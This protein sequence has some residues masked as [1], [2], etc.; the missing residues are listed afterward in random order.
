MNI[1][2]KGTRF[3][4]KCLLVSALLA[5]S[6]SGVAQLR[7]VTLDPKLGGIKITDLA[8][9][10]LN[11]NFIQPGQLLKI[12]VPVAN[13]IH[14]NAVPKGSCKI[15]IGLGSKLLLDPQLD[16]TTVNSSNYFTWT[17]VTVGGQSL[18]TG[19]LTT[20]LPANFNEVEVAFK[21]L[22]NQV[23][24]STITANFLVTNH[25]TATILSDNDGSNNATFLKYA[26]TNATAP[27]P[28]TTVDALSK[29]DCSIKIDFSTDR[30]INISH[31]Q[32][33]AS[34]NAVDYVKVYQTNAAALATYTAT[35]ALPKDLQTPVL[36]VRAKTTYN[37]GNVM[38]SDAK[39][40]SGLCEGKWAVDMYPNPTRGNEDVVIR[41]VSG[42]FNGRYTI[43]LVDLTGRT[44]QTHQV[45]LNNVLNFKYRIGNL[46]A[47]K[48][49]LRIVNADA[50]ETA[51]LQFEKL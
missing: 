40:V 17:A 8:G 13:T 3:S 32:L 41:A 50:S 2:L 48:Y 39:T 44:I 37:N 5:A 34:K 45:Q 28:T 38:Y 36:Y 6:L 12:V 20:A 24:H 47:S 19:E 11:E 49:M 22:G 23:G 29:S 42:M 30:E 51:L 25:N 9:N 18:L 43:N 26:I 10:V 27:T 14:D 16:L 35:I 33:E 15:K 1:N 21:V 4:V 7:A 31:Y 46:A